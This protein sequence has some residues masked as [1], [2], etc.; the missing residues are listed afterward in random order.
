ME[1]EFPQ[2]QRKPHSDEVKRLL[3]RV[4]EYDK[5]IEEGDWSE[6]AQNNL[7]DI[8]YKYRWGGD[9]E[10]VKNAAQAVRDKGNLLLARRAARNGEI[11]AAFDH[12]FR[13]MST[14]DDTYVKLWKSLEKKASFGLKEHELLNKMRFLIR[15]FVFIVATAR[16]NQDAFTYPYQMRNAPP[17]LLYVR[18]QGVE[19]VTREEIRDVLL[20]SMMVEVWAEALFS[21][22]GRNPLD[23]HLIKRINTL[24]TQEERDYLQQILDMEQFVDDFEGSPNPPKSGTTPKVAWRFT[25]NKLR[26]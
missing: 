20:S 26:L 22:E 4:R 16:Q 18:E 14:W 3:Q 23:R 15:E 17:R 19:E 2:V 8:F 25:A 1:P 13:L 12:L 7:R 11:R 24:G 5:R 6:A 10:V 21:L 9:G